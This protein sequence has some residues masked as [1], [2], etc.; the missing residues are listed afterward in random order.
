MVHG[1]GDS[2]VM[3]PNLAAPGAAAAAP[4]GQR[5]AGSG[6]QEAAGSGGQRGAGV[7]HALDL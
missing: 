4:G 5:A 3:H 2:D 1:L 7:G 6:A